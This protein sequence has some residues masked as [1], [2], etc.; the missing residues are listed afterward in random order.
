[1]DGHKVRE[2]GALLLEAAAK[3]VT[4]SIMNGMIGDLQSVAAARIAAEF[5][6]QHAAFVRDAGAA[7]EPFRMAV[8]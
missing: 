8:R 5:L 1:M 7:T 4:A 2:D 3:I 6:R